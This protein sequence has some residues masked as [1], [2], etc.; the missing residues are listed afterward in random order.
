MATGTPALSYLSSIEIDMT[1]TGTQAIESIR[2]V[3]NKIA[4]SQVDN[5]TGFSA[6]AKCLMENPYVTCSWDLAEATL[7]YTVDFDSESVTTISTIGRTALTSRRGITLGVVSNG[8]TYTIRSAQAV[9][10]LIE[11][12]EDVV[13]STG[14]TAAGDGSHTNILAIGASPYES[15][16]WNLVKS[17]AVYTA[18]PTASS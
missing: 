4:D 1:A 11:K 7:I 3:F 8:N 15:Y 18:T 14:N 6:T 17:N 2:A 12:F 13:A 10:N 5:L 9:L 16:V